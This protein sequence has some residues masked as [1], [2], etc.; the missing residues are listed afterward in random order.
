MVRVVAGG[1]DVEGEPRVVGE[2]REHVRRQ[3]GVGIDG[4]LRVATA[5]EVD[6]G[7][8]AGVVHD[9]DRVA[10]A[11]DPLAIAECAVERLAE[12]DRRVL[13]GVVVAGLEIA[14]PLEHEVEA[15]VE[16]ELF[17]EVVVQAG[18]GGDTHAAGAVE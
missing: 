18:A 5:A 2:A 13:G 12:C 15:G 3:A 11:R 6:G 1:I 10:V 17:E 14:A 16:R 9:D 7:A 8:R 4:D